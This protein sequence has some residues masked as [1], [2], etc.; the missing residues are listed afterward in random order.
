MR[1]KS[2]LPL[3]AVA[4]L[5]LVSCKKSGSDDPTIDFGPD[6]GFQYRTPNNVPNGGDPTDW[7]ADGAWNDREKQLFS[8]LGLPLDAPQQTD[9]Y[10]ASVYPN[11]SAA[12]LGGGFTFFTSTSSNRPAPTGTRLAYVIVDRKY[13]ELQRGDLLLM[14]RGISV[15][16]MPSPLAAGSL[17][18]LY[19]VCYVPGQQVNYRSHG[20]IKTE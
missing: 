3:L 5:L 20:D 18:R 16:F 14:P 1:S 8:S 17:N 2:Y 10:Y 15:P 4:A 11:P 12:T 13:Q 19:L 6:P 9:T 7:A